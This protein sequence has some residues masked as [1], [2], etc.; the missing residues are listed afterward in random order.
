MRDTIRLYT[1]PG[2]RPVTGANAAA[3]ATLGDD[4][5]RAF[6]LDLRLRPQ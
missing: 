6:R 5:E 1:R 4:C 2:F 3:F